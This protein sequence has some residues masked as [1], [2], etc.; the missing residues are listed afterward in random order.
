[1]TDASKA[2]MDNLKGIK[3]RILCSW[4]PCSLATSM[5]FQTGFV[6]R[7]IFHSCRSSPRGA[8]LLYYTVAR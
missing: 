6:S 1:V 7:E 8:P 4:P 5:C 3:V 2:F